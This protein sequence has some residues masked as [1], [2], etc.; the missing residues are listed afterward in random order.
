MNDMQF[1]HYSLY[2]DRHAV[3]LEENK[4]NN[5]KKYCW[6]LIRYPEKGRNAARS[7]SRTLPASSKLANEALISL[8]SLKG[9]TLKHLYSYITDKY[10]MNITN[11]R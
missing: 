3:E 2:I 1:F 11:Q 7:E 4:I 10:N 6:Q 9:T 5:Y 8:Y